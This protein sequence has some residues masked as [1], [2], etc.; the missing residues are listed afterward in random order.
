MTLTNTA[1][2]WLEQKQL[3]MQAGSLSD[4]IERM[5]REQPKILTTDL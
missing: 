2:L 4:V 3:S 1:I 5:A